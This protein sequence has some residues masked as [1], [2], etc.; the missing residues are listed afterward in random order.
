MS[1]TLDLKIML[2]T[3]PMLIF[4]ERVTESAIIHA[5]RDIQLAASIPGSMIQ[6]EIICPSKE[7]TSFA[8]RWSNSYLFDCIFGHSKPR[9]STAHANAMAVKTTPTK[10]KAYIA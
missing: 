1:L 9:A 5:R 2:E 3:V 7:R 4:G 8:Q 10:G 6:Q